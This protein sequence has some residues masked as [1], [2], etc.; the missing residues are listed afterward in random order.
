LRVLV[1][2][3]IDDCKGIVQS[4]LLDAFIVAR[5]EPTL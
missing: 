3:N 4:R 2:V 1:N 5:L